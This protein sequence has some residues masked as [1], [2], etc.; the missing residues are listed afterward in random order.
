MWSKSISLLILGVAFN[1]TAQPPKVYLDVSVLNLGGPM[2]SAFR[3]LATEFQ[4]RHPGVKVRLHTESDANYKKK[5]AEWL[6][7]E[8]GV[9]VLYWQAGERLFKLVREDY[10]KPITSL[11]QQQKWNNAFSLGMQNLVK[12]NNEFYAVPFSYYHWAVYYKKSTFK[13]L[14]ITPPANWSELISLCKKIREKQKTPIV[15]GNKYLWPAESWFDYINLRLN[16]IEFHQALLAGAISYKD[17]RVKQVFIHWKELIEN[18]CFNPLPEEY[19]WY[20]VL[21]EI[22][23]E[24]ATMMLMGH[25][26]TS[27]ASK[28][29]I[30]DLDFFPFP[31]INPS[32]P[33][34]EEAPTDVF[35]IPHNTKNLKLAEQF[36]I[37]VA[38]P[39]VQTTLNQKMKFLPPRLGAKV[40]D[41]VLIKKG[42]DLLDQAKGITQFFDRDAP[43]PMVDVANQ[44]FAEFLKTTEVESIT[45]KLEAARRKLYN[46]Q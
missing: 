15:L 28:N 38:Q 9:D 32:I 20:E 18:K 41:Q 22:N 43:K 2:G 40:S 46:S 21:P 16:G 30:N 27:K 23:R 14:N 7:A 34:Y 5:L 29:L 8:K 25:F 13:K 35:T 3:Y 1:V 10:L 37:M 12:L 6:S 33:Q 4:R 26:I 17:K 24:S 11:W 31:E 36:L 19:D 39:D 42:K 44:L 45:D